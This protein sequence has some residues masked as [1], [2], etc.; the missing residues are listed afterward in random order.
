MVTYIQV[1]VGSYGMVN[2]EIQPTDDIREFEELGISKD[3]FVA[4]TDRVEDLGVEER[5]QEVARITTATATQ[6]F[7]KMTETIHTLAKGFRERMDALEDTIR[8]DEVSI[9]FGI[10]LKA[11][12]GVV[13]AQA[14][15]DA[16]FKVKLAWKISSST[17]EN[18]QN[19]INRG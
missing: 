13:V 2:V 10:A 18:G 4:T 9:E 15:A 12:A 8:P 5:V 19:A 16:S 6:A 1:P 14:G 17:R 7:E 3:E 11:G